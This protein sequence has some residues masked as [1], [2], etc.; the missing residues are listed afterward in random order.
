M[1]YLPHLAI[2]K[3]TFIAI[4]CIVTVIC[5]FLLYLLFKLLKNS[6]DQKFTVNTSRQDIQPHAIFVDL[7]PK[8]ADIVELAV[9]VWRINNRITKASSN[10]TE[11][12]KRGIE[13]SLQKFIRFFD[14]YEIKIIDH[15]GEK[16]NEGTNVDV[17]SFERD[18]NIKT[19]MVKE[20]IEPS[21]T[22]KGHVIKKGKIIVINK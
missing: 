18:E 14:K 9:E 1:N 15:T 20:T 16:Y 11:I 21:I 2:N 12:Q 4:L 19:P 22:C 17:L 10:L 7:S 6:K 8:T 5:F 3:F 13:S